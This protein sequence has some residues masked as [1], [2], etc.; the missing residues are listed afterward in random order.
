MVRI[1]NNFWI[2]WK[3]NQSFLRNALT[4]SNYPLSKTEHDRWCRKFSERTYISVIVDKKLCWKIH[5]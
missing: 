4:V 3:R 5:I 1:L 2:P